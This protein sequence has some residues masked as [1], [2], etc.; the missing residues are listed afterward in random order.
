MLIALLAQ[1]AA[2]GAEHMPDDAPPPFPPFEPWHMPGQ[3]FWLAILF[4]VLYFALSRFILPKMSDTIEKRSDRIASDLDQA[5]VLNEQAT[6]AQQALE[7]RIAQAKAKARETA[8]KA[9]QK[10]DDEVSAQTARVDAEIEK[11]LDAAESRITEM[12]AKAM[13]NVEQI[14]IDTAD[15]MT[16]RFGLKASPAD[17]KKAVSASLK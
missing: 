5:S 4:A 10:I 1:E 15:A 8:A 7:L 9:K 6:E 11:K 13:Q 3:L 17:L 14:A 2:H 12:R 16:A